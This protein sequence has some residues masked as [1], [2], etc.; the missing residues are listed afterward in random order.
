MPELSI[1]RLDIRQGQRARAPRIEGV[2]LLFN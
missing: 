1:C 2:I